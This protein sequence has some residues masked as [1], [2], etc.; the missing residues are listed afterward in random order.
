MQKCNEYL[1]IEFIENK[2]DDYFIGSKNATRGSRIE[3]GRA[4][5]RVRKFNDKV[6]RRY[7]GNGEIV[8]GNR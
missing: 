7:K 1:F 4:W 6:R 3:V 8:E 5:T 2:S